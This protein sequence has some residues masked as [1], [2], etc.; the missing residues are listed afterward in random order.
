[1]KQS[2]LAAIRQFALEDDSEIDDLELFQAE[3]EKARAELTKL[4]DQ[5]LSTMRKFDYPADCCHDCCG[6]TDEYNDKLVELMDNWFASGTVSAK[7]VEHICNTEYARLF[8]G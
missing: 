7:V 1:M 2:V 8:R 3:L 6:W 4:E 5:V